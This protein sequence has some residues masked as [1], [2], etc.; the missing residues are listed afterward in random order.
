VLITRDWFASAFRA[1]V[2]VGGIRSRRDAAALLG[3]GANGQ[4]DLA[5]TSAFTASGLIA[6]DDLS[7]MALGGF[8]GSDP[9]TSISKVAE[10]VRSG[11]IRFFLTGGALGT[12]FGAAVGGAGGFGARPPSN[13]LQGSPPQPARPVPSRRRS[14]RRGEEGGS[15]A[16]IL[17][18]LNSAGGVAARRRSANR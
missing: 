2:R 4:W 8:L 16:R 14:S 12:R 11:Q 5:T 10:Q 9:A 13:A 1:N 17:A 7:V 6:Q 18:R 3:S 15:G